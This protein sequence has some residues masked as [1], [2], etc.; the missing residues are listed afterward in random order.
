ME[1]NMTDQHKKSPFICQ[2]HCHIYFSFLINSK[3]KKK[4]VRSAKLQTERFCP[5]NLGH[6]YD[7]I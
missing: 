7:L 3:K 2:H 6:K 1:N 5:I 4:K